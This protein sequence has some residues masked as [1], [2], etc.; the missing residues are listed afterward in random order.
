MEVALRL[1]REILPEGINGMS[2]GDGEGRFL[3]AVNADLSRY[4]PYTRKEL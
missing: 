4:K 1:F 3:I 2:S